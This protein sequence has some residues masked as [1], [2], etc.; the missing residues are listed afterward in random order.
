MGQNQRLELKI[1]NKLKKI[2]EELRNLRHEF[3]KVNGDKL[4]K[5]SKLQISSWTR[6][7]EDK[8]KF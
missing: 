5:K 7:R 2:K 1:I 4:N 8:K 3:S 6:N